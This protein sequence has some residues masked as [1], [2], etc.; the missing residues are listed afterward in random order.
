[1]FRTRTG[2]RV[3]GIVAGALALALI[4]A[5]AVWWVFRDLGAK[6]ITAYFG[7]TVGVYA[8][9]DL[10]VLGVRVGTVDSVTPVGT[11]VRVTMTLDHDVT[12]PAGAS[13]VVVS[14]S[15]VSDRYVQ[16]TPAY[17]GG[18][19]LADGAVIP[20]A[21]TATPVELDQLYES[22]NKL[23]TA[24][25]PN[26]ANRNGALSD[27]L[28][29][30]AKNLAGNGQ[31]LGTVIDQL[32][33]AARTLSGSS[34]NLFGT[35]ANLQQF[36][37][38]LKNNDGQ[39]R[40]AINQLASVSGFLAG[41]R[42]D[43]GAALSELATALG[44]VRD[45]VANNRSLIKSN[46]DKLASIT[47]VLVNQRASLAES[48]DVFPLAATNLLNA[49]DPAHRTLDGRADLL[50]LFPTG[51]SGAATAS[52]CGA[53]GAK[54]N[55]LPALA[56]TCQNAPALTNGLAP[57]TSG[58]AGLPALP[59]PAVGPVYGPASGGGH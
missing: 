25:G 29:T 14:P 34:E 33:A 16:L 15:V 59:L 40:D 56:A 3:A 37:T 26:G 49:Y 50:G 53:A 1:M 36:T 41:D 57:V 54:P 11:Q 8:G 9:S 24:L 48:L 43:L 2:R 22:L 5:G 44:Q 19:A 27:L 28:T 23:T 12:V 45:F 30:G 10:R 42:Q 38:M 52:V 20:V 6:Q 58:R 18:P 7:E 17:T 55:A 35:V 46:V 51:S 47:R 13:A 4:C 32:G 21:R 39:V 31:A